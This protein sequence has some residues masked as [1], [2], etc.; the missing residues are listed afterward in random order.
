MPRGPPDHDFVASV[1]TGMSRRA[2]S[3]KSVRKSV[4]RSSKNPCWDT[5]LRISPGRPARLYTCSAVTGTSASL[6]NSSRSWKTGW[7]CRSLPVEDA[8]P[9]PTAGA[10]G[11]LPIRSTRVGLSTSVIRNPTVSA[12]S[13]AVSVTP[14]N[15]PSQALGHGSFVA[16]TQEPALGSV[17]PA[18]A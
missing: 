2:M 13:A 4:G 11:S 5:V 14:G 15:V 6:R 8:I 12:R 17:L 1:V 18:R 3:S 9:V 7:M 10:V 16:S